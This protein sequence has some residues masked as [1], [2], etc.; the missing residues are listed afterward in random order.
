MN[1]TTKTTGGVC[2]T[3]VSSPSSLLTSLY[4][5]AI[6][7]LAVFGVSVARADPPNTV[8]FSSP[9][10][11]SPSSSAD[12]G[13][14]SAFYSAPVTFTWSLDGGP[15]VTQPGLGNESPQIF[16]QF[17][18]LAE[19]QHTFTVF[20]TDV[21]TGNSD[22]TP[23]TWTWTVD[24]IP[25]VCGEA[26]ALHAAIVG[27]QVH[28]TAVQPDGKTILVGNFTQVLGQPR[29]HI[30]RLN[31]DGTL[32]AGFD[33]NTNG[34]VHAVAVEADGQILLGGD[35]TSI[36]GTGRNRIARL[37]SDGTLDTDF[38]PG[39]D[40]SV[41]CL[42]LD[43]DGR[44]LL[45]G[46]FT[47]A[48]GGARNFIARLS[49]NGVLDAGFDPNANGSVR[50]IA[51]E[52]DGRILLGG[53]FTTIS[54]TAR[55]HIARVDGGGLLDTGFDPDPNGIVRCVALQADGRILLGGQFS[56]I[57][58]TG[59]NA[60]ARVD[61]TGALETGFDPNAGGGFVSSIAVQADGRILLGGSFT[62]VGGTGRTRLARVDAAGALD[63]GFTPNVNGDVNSVAMQAD[64]RI[65]LGGT[66]TTV[67]I[68][69]VG[70]GPRNLF[71]RLF[72]DP[73]PQPLVVALDRTQITWTRGGTSPEISQVTFELSTD[74]GTT[75]TP[76]GNPAR[77]G[78]TP[79]WQLTGL[80]LPNVGHI[81]ARGRTTSG[82]N[83]GSSGLMQ[84]A[85]AFYNHDGPGDPDAF[86][87]GM[88]L[89]S[90]GVEAIA[91][92]PDGKTILGG[93]FST[94]LGE[95]RNFLARL[96]ADDTLD[97]GF[98]PD[99]NNLVRCVAVQPDG[100][101]LIGGNFTM[102]NGVERNR[103]ARLN[104]DGTL[105][106][107]FDP[108]VNNQVRA[109]ALHPDGKIMIGGVFAT[110]GG[111]S[112]PY[113]ARLHANGTLDTAFD[114]DSL[115]GW[116][117]CIVV[118]PNGKVILAGDFLIGGYRPRFARFL[119]SGAVDAAT[120]GQVAVSDQIRCVAV[121]ADGKFLIG[122]DFPGK[123]AR[124]HPNGFHDPSFSAPVLD[125]QVNSMAVQ[126]DGKIVIAGRFSMVNDIQR[127]RVARLHA[128]G[129]PD[130]IFNPEANAEA[131]GVV[132]RTDGKILLGG[133]FNTVDGRPRVRFARLINDPATQTLGAASSSQ[134][135]WNRGGSAP[136]VSLVTFEKS[137][138]GGATWIPLGNG[139]RI[140]ATPNWQLTGLTLPGT[141]QLRARGRTAG[142]L[143]T[144][145]SSIIEQV[146]AFDLMFTPFQQWKYT[147]LGDANAPN[148]GD[149]DNDGL[150]TI[151]EYATGGDPLVKGP[152][153]SGSILD[154]KMTITFPRNTAATDITLTVQA[155]D[156]LSEWTDIARSH[157]GAAML[158]LLPGV[159][160]MET[161][162]GP[163]LG[164]EVR[165]LLSTGAP[166]NPKGF[167]RLRAAP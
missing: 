2:G 111:I 147:R 10:L 140:G 28:A 126:A 104:A 152:L 164:V 142:G 98:N 44:I 144:G 15:A 157:N 68:N 94:V 18:N 117:N 73:A 25:P 89:A 40:G 27:V 84:P 13:I 127:Y 71:A 19:G 128:D 92:Q 8:I 130:P 56:M 156:D 85:V 53:Q 74:F 62:S 95:G 60:I 49:A 115:D 118:E 55:N 9:A 154:N 29:N 123:L 146:T 155:S 6:L 51:V 135:T 91:M 35:F 159:T 132:I 83:N 160:V 64:G 45:G 65:L 11:V 78:T 166:E 24:A 67:M 75:W 76:L 36:G 86:D 31:A 21:H 66:F 129:T 161:G 42:A 61:T 43:A 46:F 114:A 70:V 134:V 107:G 99:V 16:V 77:I 119:A 110:V 1:M 52:T 150:R 38:D 39:A 12:F 30:A 136:E 59:R 17:I 148:N 82:S 162:E 100:K 26:D 131:A 41:R 34:T 143:Y 23:A 32:D 109:I 81:R 54:G 120:M 33:P 116:V 121:Q 37:H 122:G 50:S 90:G 79:D 87:A 93:L 103:I 69:E 48:G 57:G 96:N 106:T 165:N 20:A 4:A 14:I 112:R 88:S 149:D 124:L 108:N 22:P 167:L 102:V 105:D 97:I 158:A 58:G 63:A 125:N 3:A 80:A 151:L 101:I 113:A 145:S 47:N 141:G 72:N 138:D 163:L 137:T 5:K 7:L 133:L 139:T 153:P